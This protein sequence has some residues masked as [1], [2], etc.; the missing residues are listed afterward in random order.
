MFS[1]FDFS[2][3]FPGGQL[4]SFAPMRGRPCHHRKTSKSY[5]VGCQRGTARICCCAPCSAAAER[6][7]SID[8]HILPTGRSAANSGVPMTD[9]YV[10]LAFK[11]CGKYCVNRTVLNLTCPHSTRSRVYVTVGCQSVLLSVLSIDSSS[12]VRMVCC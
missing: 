3:N 11:L 5:Y 12:G 8:R 7:V 1:L 10:H 2:S 4:T 6:H 9:R